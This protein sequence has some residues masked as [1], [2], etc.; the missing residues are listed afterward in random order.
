MSEARHRIRELARTWWLSAVLLP[1]A[2]YFALTRGDYTIADSADLFVHEMG[3]LFFAPF[4]PVLRMAGGTILQL[5]V[6]AGLALYAYS[7]EYR[8]ATQLFVFWLGHSFINVSVYAA[9]A[10]AQALPL[11]S[12]AGSDNA[13]HDWHWM[14]GG[15]GV[16]EWDTAIGTG[17]WIVGVVW[18]VVA[19]LVPRRMF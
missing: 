2:I 5:L 15:L 11:V 6:P 14:L 8:I 12:L 7:Y 10:R 17:F 1:F 16:L 19:M 9:D 18:F 13:M 4:G 3:H